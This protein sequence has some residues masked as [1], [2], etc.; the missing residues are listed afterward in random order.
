MYKCIEEFKAV[1]NGQASLIKVGAMYNDDVEVVLK[2][3]SKFKKLELLIE[4]PVSELEV[5]VNEVET[6][7]DKPKVRRGRRKSK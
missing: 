3:K 6:V 1:V 7:E 4:E 2:N 5:V